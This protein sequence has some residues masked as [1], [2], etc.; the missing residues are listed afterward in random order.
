MKRAEFDEAALK[1][2]IEGSAESIDATV[3]HRLH[4]RPT[5]RAILIC[6]LAGNGGDIKSAGARIGLKSIAANM[7]IT[8][9]RERNGGVTLYQMVASFAV[10]MKEKGQQ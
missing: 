3:S 8:R 6:L 7:R 10:E 4:L 2:V 5:E 1:K 9:C